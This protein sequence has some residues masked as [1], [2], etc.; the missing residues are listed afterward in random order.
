[1]KTKDKIRWGII[2][3]GDVTE[4]KSGPAFYKLDNS[5]LLAVMRRD[6]VKAGSYASRHHVKEYYSD[7]QKIINHP[8]IDAVYIATPPSTHKEYAIAAMEAGKDVYVEKPMAL[9]ATECEEMIAASLKF[10]K[11]L[12]VAYYRRYLPGF[13]KVKEWVDSGAIGSVL[14]GRVFMLKEASEQPDKLPWRVIPEIAGGGHFVDL[15]SHQ[16]DLFNFI[17]GNAI[18]VTGHASNR[19]GIYPSEDTVAAFLQYPND[20]VVTGHWSFCSFRNEDTMEIIG[21]DGIIRFSGFGHA[22]VELIRKEGTIQF[23]YQN[24]QHIQQNLIEA[25]NMELQGGAP[26]NSTGESAIQASYA[27]DAIL[28]SYCSPRD[29]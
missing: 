29:Q 26:C 10:N 6:L 25:V 24:P 11:K 19:A 4:M 23:P 14:S 27:M 22:P 21:T 20:V 28:K 1:M 7:A 16:I 2:G 3:C 17:F 5:E 9:D 18:K 15:A 13:L 8:K 12:F